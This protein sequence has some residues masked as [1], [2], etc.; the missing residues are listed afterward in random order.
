MR[1]DVDG[2]EYALLCF[3]VPEPVLPNG[4]TPAE[5]EVVEGVVRGESNGEIARRRGVSAN[6]VANQLRSVYAKLRVGSRRELV[7]RCLRSDVG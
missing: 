7:V 2:E 6:T 4:L 5:R 1:F 3:P